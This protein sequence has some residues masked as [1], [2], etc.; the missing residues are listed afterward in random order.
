MKWLTIIS[1]RIVGILFERAGISV[2]DSPKDDICINDSS[3]FSDL[4]FRGSLGLGD[5]YIAEKWDSNK[6]DELVFKILSSGI[7]PEI[8]DFYEITRIIAGKFSNPQNRTGAKKVIEQ[9]Y[10]LSAGFF[11][12]FLDP[13]LQY[14]CGFFDNTESLDEAQIKKMDLVC[15]KLKLSRGARVLDI[16]CGWGGL[17]RFMQERYGAILTGV[18]LSKEQAGWIKERMPQM[19]MCVCD[20]R[21]MPTIMTKKFDAVSAVGIFEHIGHRNYSDFMRTAS[22][23]M[24][25]EGRFLLHTLFT[26]YPAPASDPW[27]N[28]HIFPNGELPPKEFV[29]KAAEGY[30]DQCDS[31]HLAFQEL[32]PHYFPTLHAWDKNLAN[33]VRMG[34]V[35]ITEQEKRKWHFYFMS[36]AGAI[37][38]RHMKVGQFL[39]TNK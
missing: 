10:D 5:S 38:A 1:E 16:G 15:R 14:T 6:I 11:A 8:S 18:T 13:Y 34:L 9:H 2:G 33:A 37:R 12:A 27:L 26:P 7:Y 22:I 23:V 20:Y 4:L 36:C 35:N 21:D 17:A 31:D 30:F 39:F 25:K 19:E 28:K 29:L 3:F 24:K 32:T